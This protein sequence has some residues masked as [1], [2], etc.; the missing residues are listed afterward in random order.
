MRP[1]LPTAVDPT[2]SAP[3]TAQQRFPDGGTTTE[4]PYVALDTVHLA[5]WRGHALARFGDA[6]AVEVLTDA[7]DKLDCSFARAETSLRV[8]LAIALAARG[9]RDEARD[10]AERAGTLATQLGSARQDRRLRGLSAS[11]AS[12]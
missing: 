10:H 9:E 4:R 3:S 11:L 8:D 5:R 2:A 7:L 6:D 1:L 12:G